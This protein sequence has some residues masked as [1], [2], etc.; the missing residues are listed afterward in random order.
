MNKPYG[1]T[2]AGGFPVTQQNGSQVGALDNTIS[3]GPRLNW[4]QRLG[5]VRMFSNSYDKQTVLPDA[6]LG[7]TFGIGSA[8]TTGLFANGLMPGLLI[9]EFASNFSAD[10]P[11]LAVGP[12]ST[13]STHRHRILPEPLESFDERDLLDWKAHSC[14]RRWLQLYAVEHREQPHPPRQCRSQDL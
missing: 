11:A 5:F 8:D 3:I 2:V 9:N 13:E 12:Y 10:A 14:G 7:P 4:E 6:T 1:L